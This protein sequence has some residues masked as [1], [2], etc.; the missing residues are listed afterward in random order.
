MTGVQILLGFCHIFRSRQN[1]FHLYLT[2]ACFLSHLSSPQP[3]AHSLFHLGNLSPK[4][5]PSISQRHSSRQSVCQFDEA[6]VVTS[7]GIASRCPGY[8]LRSSD[9]LGPAALLPLAGRR[10]AWMSP[11][12][13]C[14][15]HDSLSHARFGLRS[16][17]KLLTMDSR[18]HAFTEQVHS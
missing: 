12:L 3:M 1:R 11:A 9:N 4:T 15:G 7:L 16:F 6:Q 17:R 8:G 13:A 2:H 14:G 18:T 5:L 10:L